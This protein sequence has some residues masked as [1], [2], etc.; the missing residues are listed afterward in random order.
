MTLSRSTV[1]P[2]ARSS[3]AQAA[4]AQAAMCRAS[5]ATV[6]G[7]KAGARMRRCRRQASPSLDA[8]PRPISA[9]K[10]RSPAAMRRYSS[11]R[12]ASTSRIAS[13]D[14]AMTTSRPGI[15]RRR[16]GWS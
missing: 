14:A 4:S 11:G 2:R 1:S 7:V 8:T 12:V 15:G 16:T 5:T 6:R 9:P 3:G 10:M 13:G